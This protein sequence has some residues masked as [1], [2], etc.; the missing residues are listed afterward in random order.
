MVANPEDRFSRGEAQLH[1]L[2]VPLV[3]SFNRVRYCITS[4]L[5][6]VQLSKLTFRQCLK[7]LTKYAKPNPTLRF[8]LH[9]TKV[10]LPPYILA[11]SSDNKSKT[12]TNFSFIQRGTLAKTLRVIL[13]QKD[14]FYLYFNRCSPN[15]DTLDSKSH[16]FGYRLNKSSEQYSRE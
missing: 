16:I 3:Q 10:I 14:P 1:A 6:A 11:A 9:L 4:F 2:R 13:F 12:S 7:K 8:I 5:V 15:K